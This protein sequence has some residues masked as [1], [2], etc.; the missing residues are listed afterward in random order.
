MELRKYANMQVKKYTCMQLC[1][2]MQVYASLRVCKVCMN[3]GMKVCKYASIHG[4]RPEPDREPEFRYF[5]VP[6]DKKP[7]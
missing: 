3:K 1:K 6:V 7:E 5:P 4:G 2:F